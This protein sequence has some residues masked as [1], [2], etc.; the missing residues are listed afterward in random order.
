M[1]SKDALYDAKVAAANAAVAAQNA[2][3]YQAQAP[4]VAAPAPTLTQEPAPAQTGAYNPQYGNPLNQTAAP[5]IPTSQPIAYATKQIYDRY[6][7]L[8][9]IYTEGPN[10]GRDIKTNEVVVEGQAPAGPTGSTG[11]TGPTG[12]TGASGATGPVK[13]WTATDGTVFTDQNAFVK[14]QEIISSQ[15]ADKASAAAQLKIAEE[16]KRAQ[17]QSAY[18]LLYTQ[19]SKYGL[20]S[21]VEPLKG[22]ITS[23]I[24]PSEFTIKLRETPA[25]QQRFSANA[26]RIKKGLT[27]LDEKAYLDL[28]DQYQNVMR[29]YGLPETYWKRGDLGTQEGFN[30]LI[31]NDVSNVELENRILTAQDRVLKSN[32]QVLDTLKQFYPG[33]TNGDILAYSLDPANALKDIQRK[34]TAA[35]I[36]G[37]ATA[38]GLSLGKTPAEIAASEARAQMLAGYGV[39]KEAAMSGFQTVADSTRGSQLANFYN[40][41]TYG[42]MEAEQEVFKLEGATAARKKRSEITGL[43]KA[44]FG[45][46]SGLTSSALTRDRA[47]GY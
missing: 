33:I 31:A 37:A 44:T 25:Y 17:R 12:G 11:P 47:G 8:V 18:D 28:E 23:G 46:Q 42:Q 38:A 26:E 21:L 43:E 3:R 4:A 24:S 30:K 22:F 10:A 15:N 36:G 39:T 32:P 41:P 1:P 45:G 35:E 19:F 7:T 34:V 29:N 40:R 16:E 6:G 14:Y 2:A 27:A 20:S 9:T 13:T 5:T